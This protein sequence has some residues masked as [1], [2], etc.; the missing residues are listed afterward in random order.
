MANPKTASEWAPIIGLVA[1][2]LLLVVWLRRLQN[3]RAAP[4]GNAGELKRRRPPAFAW[5][6][7]GAGV[8]LIGTVVAAW[9]DVPPGNEPVVASMVIIGA[10]CV[11]F[12]VYR[13]Y[14]S[15]K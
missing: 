4:G 8:V 14:R 9:G 3:T 15:G 12:G 6:M 1:A 11:L 5:G 7:I 2:W 13:L 10:V